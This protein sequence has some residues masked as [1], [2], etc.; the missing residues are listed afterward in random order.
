M[1]ATQDNGNDRVRSLRPR[2]PRDVASSDD[3]KGSQNGELSQG[4]SVH[5]PARR[6]GANLSMSSPKPVGKSE[7][8]KQRDTFVKVQEEC[9]L[10]SQAWTDK[11]KP[12]KSCPFVGN[13]PTI[14]ELRSWLLQWKNK[15]S[16]AERSNSRHSLSDSE[17]ST[18][19]LS[20]CYL[21]AGPPGVG[22]TSSVYYLAEELGFKVIEVHASSE[23]PGKKILAELH[24]ATQSHHVEGSRLS[25]PAVAAPNTTANTVKAKVQKKA[26]SA[27]P[28][29]QMFERAA[30]KSQE[31]PAKMVGEST[32]KKSGKGP[33]DS[34]FSANS[35]TK[36]TP[37]VSAMSSTFKPTTKT[38]P[39][40]TL[41]EYF[42]T[43]PLKKGMDLTAAKETKNLGKQQ[44]CGS[45]SGKR[46]LKKVPSFSAS[47][48]DNDELVS[49]VS[50]VKP[51]KASGTEDTKGKAVETT[52]K[53]KRVCTL[54][55]DDDIIMVSEVKKRAQ[56]QPSAEPAKVPVK[57]QKVDELPRESS[58]QKIFSVK[59]SGQDSSTLTFSSHTIILFDDVDTIFEQDDGFWSAVES[60]L[61]ITKKPVIFTATRNL[62]Q[63]RTKLPS[64]C[65]VAEFAHPK[66]EEV[67]KLAMHI[68]KSE[69][70]NL[71]FSDTVSFLLQYYH[72]DVRKCVLQL[73]L[74]SA[75]YILGQHTK[76]TFHAEALPVGDGLHKL[77]HSEVL[78]TCVITQRKFEELGLDISHLCLTNVLPLSTIPV[79]MPQ[80]VDSDDDLNAV[81][82]NNA[83]DSSWLSDEGSSDVR[84]CKPLP[85]SCIKKG[86]HPQASLIRQCLFEL[87]G[88]FD[89]F[90]TVDCLSGCLGRCAY[91]TSSLLP[92]DSVEAWQNGKT[93]APTVDVGEL[94]VPFA[95]T[96]ALAYI[97]MGS[98]K[99]AT[100]KLEK[101]LDSIVCPVPAELKLIISPSVPSLCNIYEIAEKN[102]F[103]SKCHQHITDSGIPPSVVLSKRAVSD[104]IDALQ[105]ICKC[106]ERRKKLKAKRAQRFLHYL[107]SSGI[108]LQSHWIAAL[109][110]GFRP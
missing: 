64:G 49:V 39:K 44:R 3:C 17:D 33:L 62:M 76:H 86:V 110:K 46:S 104:Y 102:R 4:P 103:W 57:K 99:L 72:C 18:E 11:Y 47:D 98:M 7:D 15:P 27:G 10:G 96:D 2:K 26:K 32:A 25:F 56:K 51:G 35:D 31:K 101:S 23:R 100:S 40:G 37:K 5:R 50:K 8:A 14:A 53:G 22:K 88:M 93:L 95:V 55:D 109:C 59:S 82:S 69:A 80:E 19:G 9:R 107:N 108:F 87:A 13:D 29:Q 42:A 52:R 85:D 106:E 66:P 78:D 16:N 61:T 81:E 48:D 28:L 79:T 105:V 24:E 91:S 92:F 36:Q 20:N 77:L 21:L 60:V 70:L 84:E 41:L 1:P 63:I 12:S 34:Y 90:S 67:S 38:S 74:D 68:F 75:L 73:Q 43:P 58:L 45:H 97:K 94:T 71:P 6:R 30:A 54:S 65:P 89:D 83:L